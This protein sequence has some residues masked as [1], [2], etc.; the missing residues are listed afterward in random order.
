M[1]PSVL[2]HFYFDHIDLFYRPDSSV[3]AD[4]FS[5]F[6]HSLENFWL[7]TNFPTWTT[8]ER[9]K[10]RH[11]FFIYYAV[12]DARS[13]C[14]PPLARARAGL[15]WQQRRVIVLYRTYDCTKTSQKVNENKMRKRWMNVFCRLNERKKMCSQHEHDT[16]RGAHSPTH[17]HRRRSGETVCYRCWVPRLCAWAI[18]RLTDAETGRPSVCVRMRASVVSKRHA[19]WVHAAE[20]SAASQPPLH[21]LRAERCRFFSIRFSAKPPDGRFLWQAGSIDFISPLLMVPRFDCWSFAMLTVFP[22]CRAMKGVNLPFPDYPS[23]SGARPRSGILYRWLRH[24][25]SGTYF[26]AD[27]KCKEDH[28]WLLLDRVF[29]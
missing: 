6:P 20:S 27:I 18:G 1:R 4:N 11:Q 10:N 23:L 19:C 17:T 14:S 16:V 12:A 3:I 21:R 2:H 22:M 13:H 15:G 24:P 25:R 7:P 28:N 8:R 29:G 5:H 9:K 26:S